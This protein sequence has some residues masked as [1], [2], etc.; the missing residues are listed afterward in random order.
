LE[1]VRKTKQPIRVTRHGKPVA[2]MV[3]KTMVED[4]SWIAS[5]QGSGE[6]L[7]DIISPRRMRLGGPTRLRFSL[8]TRIWYWLVTD[9]GR[10]GKR[11]IAE[12]ADPNDGFRRSAVGNC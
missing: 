11:R 7:D 5:M 10:I 9:V 2:E 6:T 4:R 3:A 12:L 1:R 8:D